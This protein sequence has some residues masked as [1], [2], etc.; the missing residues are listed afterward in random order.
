MNCTT[1]KTNINKEQLEVI[2][3]L[4]IIFENSFF[5]SSKFRLFN[6]AILVS[7]PPT[8]LSKLIKKVYG[9]AFSEWMILYRLNYLDKSIKMELN[10]NNKIKFNE[11]IKLAGFNT[12]S[13]FYYCFKKIRNTKPK[14]YYNL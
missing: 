12:R 10:K 7:Y 4:E 11:I 9:I 1:F 14:E 8:D 13:N 5:L 6:L 3:N 2:S